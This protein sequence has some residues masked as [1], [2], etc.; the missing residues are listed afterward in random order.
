MTQKKEPPV[1]HDLDLR[2]FPS[3]LLDVVRLR[4][5]DLA[6][7]GSAEEFR[8]AVLLWCSAWHQVPASSLP[9]DDRILASLAGFGRDVASW[10]K[11]RDGAMRGFVECSDGR[12]YHLVIAEKALEALEKRE[13]NKRKTLAATAARSS[14]SLNAD[15]HD[16]RN[17]DRDDVSTIPRDVHQEKGREGKRREEKDSSSLR[18][19]ESARDD[20]TRLQIGIVE[21][22]ESAKSPSLP[23]TSRAALWIEQGYSPKIILPVIRELIRK[24]PSISSLNYF[25]GAIAEAHRVKDVPKTAPQKPAERDWDGACA[26]YKKFGRWPPDYGNPPGSASCECP[27]AILEKHEL[28]E[29]AA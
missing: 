27:K 14:K 4:D 25:D 24:K 10:M 13:S 12:F 23:D 7:I 11:V 21:A 3:M 1:P 8:A 6:V 26:M 29:R 15:R 16:D 22:F 5:S 19:D 28:V 20:L 18:S 17:D 2:D 9:N